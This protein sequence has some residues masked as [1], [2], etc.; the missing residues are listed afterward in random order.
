MTVDG[1]GVG[2]EGLDGLVGIAGPR[3]VHPGAKETAM[4]IAITSAVDDALFGI[5]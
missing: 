1:T 5:R 3:S 4:T 2:V